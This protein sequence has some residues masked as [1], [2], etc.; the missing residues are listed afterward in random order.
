MKKTVFGTALLM[1]FATLPAGMAHAAGQETPPASPQPVYDKDVFGKVELLVEQS[2]KNTTA[3]TNMDNTLKNAVTRKREMGGLAD[4]RNLRNGIVATP[5]MDEEIDK[6]A[7]DV[8]RLRCKKFSEP[9]QN[10]MCRDVELSSL[11]LIKTLRTNIANSQQRNTV[12]ETLLAE[13]NKVGDTNLK[14]AADLQVRIQTEIA[15]LQNEKN[16]VDMAIVKNE[17]QMR[18][19]NQLLISMQKKSPGDPTGTYFRIK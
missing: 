3:V 15:L 6:I 4:T 16:M 8:E 9:S 12:I 18:L 1:L 11:N 14:E 2:G 10:K 17:Q 7:K 13:L 5:A 19:Y